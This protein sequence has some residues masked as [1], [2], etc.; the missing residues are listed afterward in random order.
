M[1]NERERLQVSAG[2]ASLVRACE[3]L[4]REIGELRHALIVADA[5]GMMALSKDHN[6][7]T[8]HAL[9]AAR[10]D[11]ARLAHR[12]DEVLERPRGA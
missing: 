10:T 5:P 3:L 12:L 8:L 4:L 1:D 9:D 7:D 11:V 6:E 2:A